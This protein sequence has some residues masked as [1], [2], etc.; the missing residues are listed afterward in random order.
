[1]F[2][3]TNGVAGEIVTYDGQNGGDVKAGRECRE[4]G[5]NAEE[6]RVI[7]DS[8]NEGSWE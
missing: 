8:Q 3:I 4:G 2:G 1:M 5:A 7:L 6:I